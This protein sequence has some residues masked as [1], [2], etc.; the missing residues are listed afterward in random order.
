MS[1]WRWVGED[2][3]EG[4]VGEDKGWVNRGRGQGMG[5]WSGLHATVG[6]CVEGWFWASPARMGLNKDGDLIGEDVLGFFRWSVLEL[7]LFGC[8]FSG[9]TISPV[10]RCNETGTIWGWGR[11]CDLGLGSGAISSCF[12]SLSSIFQ[13]W[14]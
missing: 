4:W 13:V 14:K 9:G 11:W 7:S 1:R 3:D 12:F 5:W 8:V 6:P 10:L 2:K